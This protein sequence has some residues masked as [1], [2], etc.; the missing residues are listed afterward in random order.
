MNEL[1]KERM[2]RKVKS[3]VRIDAH[4]D[5]EFP[6]IFIFGKRKVHQRARKACIQ[7]AERTRTRLIECNSR[8]RGKGKRDGWVRDGRI[9]RGSQKVGKEEMACGLIS[10][11]FSPLGKPRTIPYRSGKVWGKFI[12]NISLY[13]PTFLLP[14]L[15][16]FHPD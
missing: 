15:T 11:S 9:K 5:L 2:G 1:V 13:E 7:R 3:L 14:L 4:Y 16:S 10:T 12:P 6:S 8:R